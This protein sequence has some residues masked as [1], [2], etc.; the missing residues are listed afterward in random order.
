VTGIYF[1]GRSVHLS[2]KEKLPWRKED[3]LQHNELHRATEGIEAIDEPDSSYLKS[4]EPDASLVTNGLDVNSQLDEIRILAQEATYLAQD[5]DN[6]TAKEK[7]DRALE[8]SNLIKDASIPAE[9]LVAIAEVKS[10]VNDSRAA[11]DLIYGAI[12]ELNATSQGVNRVNILYK[13][14]K[15]LAELG[16]EQRALKF[17]NQALETILMIDDRGEQANIMV[18]IADVFFKL[19]QPEEASET[20]QGALRTASKVGRSILFNILG[21]SAPI[22]NKMMDIHSLEHICEG[23]DEIDQWWALT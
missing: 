6:I 2:A 22:L 4:V 1:R 3:E 14:S 10:K 17:A 11:K 8:K 20:L 21:L 16:E 5:G 13:I 19:N 7:A 15:L 18:D 23:I 12:Q 9:L